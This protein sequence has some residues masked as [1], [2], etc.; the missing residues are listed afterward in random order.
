M[1]MV[2]QQANNTLYGSSVVNGQLVPNFTWRAMAPS[3]AA[4]PYWYGNGSKPAT[5]AGFGSNPSVLSSASGVGGGSLSVS[6]GAVDNPWSLRESPVPWA[7]L[8]LVVGVLGLRYIHWR[9][10]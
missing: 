10:E 7:I 2:N 6:P 9:A 1:A 8:F 5:L 4:A 3:Q